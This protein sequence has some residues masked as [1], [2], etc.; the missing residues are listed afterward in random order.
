[1][2]KDKRICMQL[3]YKSSESYKHEMTLMEGIPLCLKQ[4]HVNLIL[5]INYFVQ[6]ELNL[7]T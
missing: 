1:M 2:D 6:Q 4:G 5:F 3:L 7:T